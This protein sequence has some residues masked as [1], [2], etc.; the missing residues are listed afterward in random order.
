VWLEAGRRAPD[1][2]HKKIKKKEEDE[3]EE[4]KKSKKKHRSKF[5]PLSH[6]SKALTDLENILVITRSPSQNPP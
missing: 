4:K 5:I 2:C 3:K 6:S 1:S